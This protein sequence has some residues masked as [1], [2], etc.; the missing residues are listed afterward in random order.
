MSIIRLL[1]S[2]I[3]PALI[4]VAFLMITT[5]LIALARKYPR[6]ERWPT[7]G[8]IC[9]ALLPA[10]PA[11]IAPAL[12]VGGMMMGWFTPT[13]AASVTV[14]YIA[15]VS[16]F[17]YRELT[18][19]HLWNATI[20][21][22]RGTAAI[23]VICSAAALF[24]WILAVERVPQDFAAMVL[25]TTRDPVKLLLIV[26]AIFFVAGMFL[27][28]TTATLLIVP[29]V[30][31]PLVSMGIDPVHLGIMTI[32]NIMIG[33]ITPPMG[34]ALFLIADIAGV[35]MKDLLRALIPFYFPL[36]ATLAVITFCPGLILWLPGM[37]R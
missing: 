32:F 30:A 29:I 10:L 6:A 4:C 35:S 27:D 15:A 13:E 12:M 7:P 17:Y 22:I 24:G 1:V 18:W 31:P 11:I 3:A 37:L 21:T 5:Y 25:G 28:S 9:R 2:G 23:L 20:V 34:L 16:R 14:V 26:N 19:K 36:V 8:E 33:I